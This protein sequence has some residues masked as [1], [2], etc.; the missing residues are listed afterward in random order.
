M[1]NNLLLIRGERILE[2]MA[3]EL[4]EE[5]S[6]KDLEQKTLQFEPAT[7]KRQFAVDPIQ[8]IEMKLV[9]FRTS[10]TLE[11]HATAT[12]DGKKYQP[13]ISFSDVIYEDTDQNDNVSFIGSDKEEYHIMPISLSRNSVKVRCTCL[14]FR[15]RFSIWN[16]NDGSLLGDPPGPYQKK[17][18]RAPVNTKRTPG[19]CKHLMKEVIA[20]KQAGLLTQ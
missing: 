14:D 3:E 16:N 7:K 19:V 4:N 20:L 9:P 13:S 12:S 11:A 18:D 15:W 5:S 17:T 10:Q 8:I 6:Y 1:E 2:Q